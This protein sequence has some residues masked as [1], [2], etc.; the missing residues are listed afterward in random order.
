MLEMYWE[1]VMW[2]TDALLGY[3]LDG[4]FTLFGLFCNSLL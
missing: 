2:M 4:Q 3:S 1:A